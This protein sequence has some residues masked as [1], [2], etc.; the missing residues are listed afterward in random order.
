MKILYVIHQFYPEF[1]SGTE[2][3]L[4]NLSS[5]IQRDGHFIQIVTYTLS[6]HQEAVPCNSSLATRNYIYQGL[7]VLSVKHRHLPYNL[8]TSCWD[9][10]I[11]SYAKELLQ[12][13]TPYDLVH[14]AHPMRLLS[15]AKAAMDLEIP[16][17]I[18]LTDFWMMCPKT[19]LQTSSGSLCAGPEGGPVCRKLC[20]DMH[21]DF[22]RDRLVLV[23][24][25]LSAA[26]AL[27]SP[28]KFL[29]AMFEKEFPF[30]K[31]GV[32]PHG[33]DFRYLKPNLKQYSNQDDVVFAYCGT[34]A[35]NKGVHL[36]LKAFL[37]LNPGNGKLKIS[38]PA[39]MIRI[40][41]IICRISPARMKGST[42]AER[43]QILR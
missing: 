6:E 39:S 4:L 16:Y 24:E 2:K 26:K 7:P 35:P 17:M 9:P 20:V 18:T 11:Y 23:R 8:H 25:I 13:A 22:I 37:K 42:F 31:P 15:F 12:T 1:H 41:S 36:L 29:A 10:D 5:A 43:T 30:I 28:S 38:G 33:M 21:P 40:I 34:L 19:L 14:I 27:V 32:I 3:F